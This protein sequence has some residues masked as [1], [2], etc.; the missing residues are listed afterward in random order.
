MTQFRVTEY[1]DSLGNRRGWTVV[2]LPR[3]YREGDALPV[4][5]LSDRYFETEAE[6]TA[7]LQR[8][9]SQAVSDEGSAPA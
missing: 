5:H 3:D 6:A 2:P 8:L 4:S 1:H 9:A 7:E